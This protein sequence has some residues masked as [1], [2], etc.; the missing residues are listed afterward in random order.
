MPGTLWTC[1]FQPCSS[2][3]VEDTSK[4]YQVIV[5][6]RARVPCLFRKLT[7]LKALSGQHTLALMC[8]VP[9]PP[10]ALAAEEPWRSTK[11]KEM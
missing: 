5:L 8:G 3:P 6:G 1:S 2:R 10:A 9:V 7:W 11:L 4:V